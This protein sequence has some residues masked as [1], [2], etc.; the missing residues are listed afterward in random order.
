VKKIVALSTLRA[1]LTGIL[2]LQLADSTASIAGNGIPGNDVASGL[3]EANNS[4]ASATIT[5]TWTTAP[6]VD[7]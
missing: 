4:S 1:Q 7:E 6:L 2:S 5:I 3:G